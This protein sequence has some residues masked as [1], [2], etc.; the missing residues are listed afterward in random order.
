MSSHA[1]NGI[2][3]RSGTAPSFQNMCRSACSS[4]R[5]LCLW[6]GAIFDRRV[7]YI[8]LLAGRLRSAKASALHLKVRLL[9]GFMYYE[10]WPC[11][12]AWAGRGLFTSC[13]SFAHLCSGS[14]RQQE[15]VQGL[16]RH[17]GYAIWG[18]LCFI[19]GMPRWTLQLRY[20]IVMSCYCV[21]A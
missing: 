9:F 20:L 6:S 1:D 13:N 14:P 16:L 15:L 5:S 12:R 4:L 3:H 2:D 17:M 21:D 8:I 11:R 19:L 18:A 10:P 7:L